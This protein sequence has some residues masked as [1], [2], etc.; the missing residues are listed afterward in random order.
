MD[1]ATHVLAPFIL[2]EP[3]VSPSAPEGFRY[4]RWRERAA[5]LLGATLMDLDGCLGFFSLLLYEKYHRVVTHSIP[6][7][8]VCSLL[9]VLIARSWPERWLLPFLRPRDREVP[10]V[11]PRFSRLWA[12]AAFAAALH[13]LGDAITNW[14]TLRPFWPFSDWD[15]QFGWVNSLSWPML[16]LTLSFWAVQNQLLALGKRKW[17]WAAAALWLAACALF[18]MIRPHIMDPPYV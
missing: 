17:A 2:T 3:F 18:I 5:V 7:L 10:A 8:I 13:F 12:L 15:M 9:A 14:G 11:V 4:P 16:T 1:T 6:G